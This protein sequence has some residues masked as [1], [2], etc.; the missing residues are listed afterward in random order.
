MS[1]YV[2]DKSLSNCCTY[3]RIA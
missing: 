1:N 3:R 2:L